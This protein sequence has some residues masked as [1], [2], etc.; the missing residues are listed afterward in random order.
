MS[1]YGAYVWSSYALALVVVAG[2]LWSARRGLRE[3]IVH[4]RRRLQI[5][6]EAQS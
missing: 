4:A 1:G 5:N 2:N 6:K 3:Q